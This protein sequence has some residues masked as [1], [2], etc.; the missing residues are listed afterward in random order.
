M[1]PFY[2]MG[3]L[4]EIVYGFPRSAQ[5]FCPITRSFFSLQA[6]T[7]GHK[8]AKSNGLQL[9]YKMKTLSP[10]IKIMFCSA[11]EIAEELT[12]VL[13]NIE[14]NHILRKP[15]EREYLINKVNSALIEQ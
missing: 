13:P 4:C 9:F 3:D 14:Q 2:P 10:P 8:D 6:N 1:S 5:A 7:F 12:S 15:V 11:L